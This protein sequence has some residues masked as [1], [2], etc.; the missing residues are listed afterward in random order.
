MRSTLSSLSVI[1]LSMDLCKGDAP[2]HTL[3]RVSHRGAPV[4]IRH[5]PLMM[6]Q[7]ATAGVQI[8]HSDECSVSHVQ[9][10]EYLQKAAVESNLERIRIGEAW[11]LIESSKRKLKKVVLAILDTGVN[12]KHP[13]LVNQFWRDP[14]TGSIGFNFADN[15]TDVTDKD[16]HGTWCAGI[17]GAETNNSIGVAGVANVQLMILKWGDGAGDRL[18]NALKALDYALRMGATVSSH[19]YRSETGSRIFEAAMAKAATTGHIAVVGAG[20]EAKNLDKNPVYPCSIA[21][22]I[23]SM[24]CVAASP[25]STTSKAA[26]TSWSNVGAATQIAA[27]GVDI[28]STD[29]SGSYGWSYGTSASTPQVAAVA[30]LMAALGLQGQDIT[31]AITRSRTAGLSNKFNVPDVGELDALNAVKIALGQPTSP[32]RA[33]TTPAASPGDVTA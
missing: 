22:T 12:M 28:Y 4:D 3:V 10:L 8:V 7:A 24:L 21:R 27:P 25:S 33:S 9:F 1:L 18:S 23:P 13:D 11:R 30:A 16:G 31:D 6:A 19:S 14:T 17:A 26:I 5:V 32:P 20:N 15:N 2:T 29:R